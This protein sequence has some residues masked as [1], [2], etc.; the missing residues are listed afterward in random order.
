MI[1]LG[2]FLMYMVRY[3]L[4]VHIVDMTQ[5]ELRETKTSN[6]GTIAVRERL[7]KNAR[8]STKMFY[9]KEFFVNRRVCDIFQQSCIK[10]FLFQ[11]YF[12][13]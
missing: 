3:N 2:Y 13:S 1:F 12:F 10:G 5:L 7:P 11:S 8:V 4:S 9:L 6:I